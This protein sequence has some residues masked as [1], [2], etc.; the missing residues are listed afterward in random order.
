MTSLCVVLAWL[1]SADV[2][3]LIRTIEDDCVS[4][5]WMGVLLI[6]CLPP[7]GYWSLA[8]AFGAGCVLACG[9]LTNYPVIVWAPVIIGSVLLH[10]SSSADS[11]VGFRLRCVSGALLGFF[12]ALAVWGGGDD[13]R[14]H[15]LEL[16]RLRS[17]PCQFT[18]FRVV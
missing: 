5:A 10:P 8:R 4:L 7:S 14:S 9:M 12:A 18:E 1:G 13:V 15:V 11:K 2:L 17:R 6:V 16:G 3:F